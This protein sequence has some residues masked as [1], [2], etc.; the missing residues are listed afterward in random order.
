MHATD[1]FDPDFADLL[2]ALTGNDVEFVVV[3]AF[4]LGR[5]GYVRAT[6]D[7]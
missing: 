7:L 2:R 1:S 5:H 3:G 4:A 6:G